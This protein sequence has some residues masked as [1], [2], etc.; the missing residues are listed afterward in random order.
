VTRRTSFLALLVAVVL[1]VAAAV[2]VS[3]QRSVEDTT[4]KFKKPTPST[5][6][7]PS[8]LEG[9]YSQTLS[10]AD[11]F[12]GKCTTVEVPIDYAKPKGDTLRLAVKLIP[13]SGDGGRSLFYNP[14][15]PGAAAIPY[16]D[17]MRNSLGGDVL[18]HFELVFVDPRGVGRST[19]IDCLSDHDLDHFIASDPTPDNRTEKAAYQSSN[20]N[21]GKG[22]E[23]KSGPLSAHISTEEAVRDFDIV[24]ALLGSKTLDWFGSSY[25]SQLGATYATLF[26]KR[27]GRMVLDGA[28]DPS[29]TAEEASFAQNRGFQR[30]LDDYIKSCVTQSTCPLGRDAEAAQQK[31]IRFID[32]RDADPLKTGEERDLTQGLAMYGLFYPLYSEQMWPI[33]TAALAAAFRGDGSILLRLAGA[34]FQITA[35]GAYSENLAEANPAINCLDVDAVDKSSVQEVEASIPRFTKASRL[36]GRAMAW[37]ALTCTGWPIASVH[38]QIDIGAASSKPIVV[39]GT[40]RDPATPYESAVALTKQLGSA[41]LLTRE[42]DGHTAYT[43][44]NRCIKKAVDA[45]LVDGTVPKDGTICKE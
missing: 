43:S 29:L 34:Y 38:H 14:G 42:G 17:Q 25:G 37:Q 24:R 2:V 28:S 32:A 30:A 26:P 12:Q 45:Y 23:D 5:N 44:G 20:I 3:G 6:G 41:V 40:T 15:G 8:E 19:P 4:S 21:F 13:S 35:D 27:V 7:V 22:C 1:V 16:A 11:C 36:F 33:L 9:F 18:D 10:W 39:L 31:L